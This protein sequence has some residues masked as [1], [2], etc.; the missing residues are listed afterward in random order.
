VGASQLFFLSQ[1]G[2]EELEQKGN[3]PKENYKLTTKKS[4]QGGVT[5]GHLH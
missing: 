2:K 1:E 5:S 4:Q 3:N